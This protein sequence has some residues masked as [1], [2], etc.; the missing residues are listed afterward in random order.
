MKYYKNDFFRK[1]PKFKE[2][3]IAHQCLFETFSLNKHPESL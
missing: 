3:D 1:L 2:V